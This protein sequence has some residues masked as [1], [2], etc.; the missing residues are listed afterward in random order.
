MTTRRLAGPLL[1]LALTA[2]AAA[3][4]LRRGEV[5]RLVEL[6]PKEGAAGE[7]EAG[8]RRHL[9]WHQRNGDP[10]SWHGWLVA[11]G[12]RAGTFVDGTFGHSWAELDA[13]VRPREDAA[14]NA[15]NVLPYAALGLNV[16]LTRLPAHSRGPEDETLRATL[17]TVVRV[18]ADGDG[19]PFWTAADALFGGAPRQGYRVTGGPAGTWLLLLPHENWAEFGP[20]EDALARLSQRAGPA[21]GEA[22][23]ETMRRRRDLSYPPER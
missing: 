23:V 19:A 7:F 10:W 15:V 21:F 18:H 9:D 1:V 2:P 8:Y 11:T 22:Q 3:E 5:A 12:D 16:H 14:D 4:E 20:I 6:Y 17:L 13:A